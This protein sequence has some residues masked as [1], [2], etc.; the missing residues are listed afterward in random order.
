MWTSLP[1]FPT[2]PDRC[3]DRAKWRGEN[4]RKVDGKGGKTVRADLC[5]TTGP[6]VWEAELGLDASGRPLLL[7]M[8]FLEGLC[9]KKLQRELVQLFWGE[10][11]H[12]ILDPSGQR[13]KPRL[14]LT[15]HQFS[16]PFEFALDLAASV[17]RDHER[18][19]FLVLL[20]GQ[21]RL[22]SLAGR[23]DVSRPAAEP[24]TLTCRAR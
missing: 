5:A 2:L 9:L 11:F 1:I 3:G 12:T 10:G 24:G 17:G 19:H 6:A 15:Q 21:Q 4:A 23:A 13:A 18:P 7:Q 14:Q 16:L 22:Q 20:G 8:K